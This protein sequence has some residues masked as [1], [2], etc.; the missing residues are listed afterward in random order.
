VTPTLIPRLGAFTLRQE[1]GNE[2]PLSLLV[3]N[4]LPATLNETAA[5]S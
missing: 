2:S 5:A 4:I 3:M 1:F